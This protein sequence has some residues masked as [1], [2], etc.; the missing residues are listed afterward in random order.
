MK[1]L[2]AKTGTQER[3]V[4]VETFTQFLRAKIDKKRDPSELRK[5]SNFIDIDKDGFISEV[6]L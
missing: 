5:Y 4:D 2:S 1:R 3:G 6:D